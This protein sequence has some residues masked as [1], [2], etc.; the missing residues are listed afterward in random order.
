[1]TMW[2]VQTGGLT[3]TF[4]TQSKIRDIAVSTTGDYIACGSSDGSV[5]FWNIHTKKEGKGFGNGQPVVTICWISSLELAVA[6]QRTVYIC[7]ITTGEA[8][9]NF[10]ILG[11]VWGMVYLGDEGQFLVGISQPGL[12]EG[13]NSCF[14]SIIIPKQGCKSGPQE[15]DLLFMPPLMPLGEEL[16]NPTL[17]G[18]EIACITP[19][20]GVRSFNT[21]SCEL[22]NNP[23]LLNT[24]TSVAVSLNRNLVAQTRDSIQI[25]SLS[26]LQSS[27]ARNDVGSSHVYPLGE[28]HI[29][30]LL[31]PNGR[32]V[33]LELETLQELHPDDNTTLGSPPT[34]QPPS[35]HASLSRGLVAEFGI[36]VIMQAWRSGTPLPGWT[37]AANKD[38]PLLGGLSPDCSQIVTFYGSPQQELHVKDVKDGA[39]LAKRLLGD[40]LEMGEV[41]DL[42]F[43]SETRFHL[44][45]DGPG[46]HVQIPYDI[47][48]SPAEPHSHTITNGEPIFLSEPRA[49]LPY[50]LDENCE[51]VV[52][53]KSRKICWISPGNVRRGDGGHFWAGLSLIMVGDDGVVR[54]L[55]F[56]KPDS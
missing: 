54:K 11:H 37:E 56:R 23:P 34:N 39:T 4:T 40:D 53:T 26:I 49:T 36:S 51:W 18:G 52:D 24:A 29:I 27:E 55:S 25:F 7:D 17:A 15:P 2:D 43:D 32:L 50:T 5:T 21:K 14:L 22:T 38:R 12:G 9:N 1:M 41:Y 47:I 31:Q 45:I 30:S 3:H 48:P 10:P 8:S 33:L 6:T 20:S 42:I 13:Q 28:K 35:A 44:K 16:S 19:P 46:Q